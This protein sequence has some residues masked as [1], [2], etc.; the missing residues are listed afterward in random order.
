MSYKSSG[1]AAGAAVL[2]APPCLGLATP[3]PGV[4]E[5]CPEGSKN[6]TCT[7]GAKGWGEEALEDVV[8]EAAAAC[9]PPPTGLSFFKKGGRF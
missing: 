3:P 4:K 7:Q 6:W 2:F 9:P 5:A 1:G 8:V